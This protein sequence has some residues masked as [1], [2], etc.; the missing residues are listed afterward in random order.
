MALL[1]MARACAVHHLGAGF[2][3]TVTVVAAVAVTV[4]ALLL[5][6]PGEARV[7]SAVTA[8]VVGSGAVLTGLLVATVLASPRSLVVAREEAG[9]GPRLAAALLTGLVAVAA[10]ARLVAMRPLWLDEAEL[11]RTTQGSLGETLDSAR[12]AHAHPP[13]LDV[14]VW[15]SRQLFGSSDLSVRLPSLVAGV[16]LVPAV[17]MT[18]ERLYDRR[19]GLVAAAVVAVGPGFLWLS[20]TAQPGALAALLATLSILTFLY[21][22]QRGRTTDW[23]LFGAA[24]A[25]LLWT[26]Q[27]A[28]AHVAVL[29]V[30][31]LATVVHRH[32]EGEPVGRFA[33]GWALAGGLTLAALI[34][35]L[36]YRGGF[37]PRDVL[38][39]FEYATRGAPGAGRSVFGLVGTGLVGFFGFHPSDVTSRLLAVWP[40]CIV[41]TF[42]LLG[43][44]WSERGTVLASLVL[45]PFVT[46]LVLQI[47]GVP[48]NPP[49]ALTWTATAVPVLAIAAGAVVTRIGRWRTT[50]LV[51]LAL[52]LV[53][54]VAAVDQSRRVQPLDRFDVEPALDD[55]HAQVRPGDAVVYAPEVLGDLVRRES[56]GADVV[57]A[58]QATPERVAGAA[59]VIV[60]GAFDFTRGDPSLDQT[61]SL[62]SQLAS[63][64]S[65]L[66]ERQHRQ[67]KVWTF[68]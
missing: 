51:G 1:A 67:A 56:P 53:L 4:E 68:Q 6:D 31:V 8:V 14:L 10:V 35:L 21:S 16:L 7:D 32:R 65:L 43:R 40:L 30:A 57:P 49:F 22:V 9:D 13:L 5:L 50:R 29:H 63:Q 11:L 48:R 24:D 19:V 38:P 45:A 66:E 2:P 41:A 23:V 55:V 58:S 12:A 25:A 39:P 62:V 47:A 46:L 18:A 44:R 28:L 27:L 42:A 64:R 34:A 37:G 59:H 26:H 52:A 54:V 17:Y 15:G 3:T 20:E 33:A 61:L 36:V 60:F